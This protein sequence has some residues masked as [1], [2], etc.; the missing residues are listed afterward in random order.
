MPPI[1]RE[2]LWALVVA[3]FV[4][5]CWWVCFEGTTKAAKAA[6]RKFDM[7]DTLNKVVVCIF[8]GFAGVALLLGGVGWVV[9]AARYTPVPDPKPEVIYVDRDGR[10]LNPQPVVNPQ[11]PIMPAVPN[12]RPNG[13]LDNGSGS[14]G[15]LG[16][17]KGAK[18]PGKK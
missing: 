10:P 14:N 11:Q 18:E 16:D 3:V 2:L 5:L 4:R 13:S 7:W 17:L 8:L 12:R 9:Y 15:S 6:G 1:V